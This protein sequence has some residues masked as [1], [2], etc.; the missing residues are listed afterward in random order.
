[1]ATLFLKDNSKPGE[2]S[3]VP[4]QD[5]NP[6]GSPADDF[7]SERG[8][9]LLLIALVA[10]WLRARD[11]GFTTAYMDE[12]IYVVYGRM[13]LAR[14]FE[15]P[16]DSP[17]RW[18]FGW[19]LWPMM[20][21]L[22]DRWG[23]LIAIRELSAA[24]GT[25]SVIAVYGFS[26]RLFGGAVGLGSAA[27][28]AV[29]GPAVMASRIAT[30]DAG[31]IFF[32][33]FG[34]WAFVY[35]WQTNK[36]RGWLAAAACL[37]CAFLCKYI[38]AIYFVFFGL[39]ALRRGWRAVLAFCLP[40]ALAL[41]GYFAFYRQDLQYLL[42]YGG[43]YGSLR[44]SASEVWELYVARR[45]ELWVIALLALLAL[46]ERSR[47]SGSVLLLLGAALALAFQ[48]KTRADFDFWK[49]AV[50]PLIFL[51]PA[52]VHAMLSA[53]KRIGETLPL[54]A[55]ISGAGIL[56]LCVFTLWAGKSLAY[57]R[58]VFWPN[59]EPILSYFE[60][61]LP[62]NGR[63]LIDDSVLRYYF[64]PRLRQSQMVDPFYFHYGQ[65]QGEAAYRAAVQDGW[66]DYIVLDG[67]M[68]GEAN[69]LRR[70]IQ[71]HHQ[72]YWLRVEMPDPALGQS[73]QIYQR[74]ESSLPAPTSGPSI[75]IFSPA[76]D[77]FVGKTGRI[78]GTV[79]GAEAGWRIR[80]EVFTNRWYPS[81]ELPLESDGKF[82][83]TANFGGEGRQAC[84][85]MLRVRAY[86]QLGHPRA[87]SLLFNLK[88]ESYCQ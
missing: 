11:P 52:A 43:S 75:E 72:L 38:V 12:S 50:Y 1:M 44:A 41:G 51:V 20:S 49:H 69:A 26:R 54:Q 24:L 29:M 62:E 77:S 27:V 33:V 64:H 57:D 45:I 74:M 8:I 19:Y 14:H 36:L 42:L 87:V 3:P 10:F 73:I 13:F 71:E 78:S 83:T 48:W 70:A 65:A 31:S 30:R 15:A 53:A 60:G 16:L 37:I 88:S 67:G 28:F 18:S 40:M 39:L 59:V 34:L 25:A 4:A 56:S 61:R 5:R 35:A 23:G 85:H 79:H 76:A 55:A 63:I 17:L 22:A 32:F 86:D 2:S 66:F 9:A 7:A 47:R 80:T 82:E 21:A 58:A 46:A 84:H 6:A 68:G 81:G